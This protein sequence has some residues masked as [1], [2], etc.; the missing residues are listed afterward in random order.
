MLYQKMLGR[1]KSYVAFVCGIGNFAVHRH[2][3]IELSYCL[4]GSYELY[5]EHTVYR[6][7]KGDL[8]MIGAMS[9]H[10]YAGDGNNRCLTL[11]VGPM[12]LESYYSALSKASFSSPILH[13]G[14]LE[15][16][17]ADLLQLRMLLSETAKLC[18]EKNEF[19]DL[20]IKGKLCETCA[21]ILKNF[22]E[23]AA[24]SGKM[25]TLSNVESALER[26]RTRYA[27][28]LRIEE[29][30]ACSGYNKS[31]FCKVFKRV[32]GETFHHALNQRRVE[33]ACNFLSLTSDSVESI[34]QQT[35]FGD[36]KSFCRVFKSLTGMTPN[37]Y[38]RQNEF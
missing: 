38:R 36:A 9:A 5:I 34:A 23:T 10:E 32:T 26:I 24:V 4:E 31:N 25:R 15:N 20:R 11:E 16:E 28:P 12:F 6:M 13:L 8:A 37:T 19:S 21:C 30:A 18:I 33:V 14:N 2:P 29:V 17:N 35:G 1:D 7:Q 27:E 3:E 22:P